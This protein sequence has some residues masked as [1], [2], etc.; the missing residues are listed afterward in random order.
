MKRILFF[1]CFVFSLS[2][3]AWELDN[4]ASRVSFVTNKAGAVAEVHRFAQLDGSIDADGA[5]QVTI[6]LASID[7]LLPDRDQ[8]LRD[9]LFQVARYPEAVIK[10]EFDPAL[11]QNLSSQSSLKLPVTLDLHGTSVTLNPELVIAQ[12][13]NGSL[14]VSSMEPVV[15]YGYQFGFMEAIEELRT[16]AGLPSISPAV[17]VQFYLTFVP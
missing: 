1:S 3:S 9:I 2:V 13:P 16:I 10:A 14:A 15:V 5:A 8:R 11:L 7:T 6:E 4:S 17:T 12:L